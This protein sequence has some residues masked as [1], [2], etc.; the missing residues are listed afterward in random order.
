MTGTT[1]LRIASIA[2][3]MLW[4]SIMWWTDRP[5]HTHELALLIACG[6]LVGFGWYFGYGR[7]FRSDFQTH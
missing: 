5:L 2:F 3:A 1:Q 7:W 4:T 6:A